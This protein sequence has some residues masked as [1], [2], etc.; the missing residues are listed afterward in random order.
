MPNSEDNEDF[1]N[2][3]MKI[4]K[5]RHVKF[6]TQEEYMEMFKKYSNIIKKEFYTDVICKRTKNLEYENLLKN[7]KKNGKQLFRNDI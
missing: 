3:W 6:Y 4:I 5:D 2:K 1:I 7:T